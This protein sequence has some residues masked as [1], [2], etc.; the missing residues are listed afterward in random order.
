MFL[1]AT[2]FLPRHALH[3]STGHKLSKSPFKQIPDTSADTC[4]MP[5]VF[6]P[7]VLCKGMQAYILNVFVWCRIVQ[8]VCL[9]NCFCDLSLYLCLSTQS[10]SACRSQ[11]E[12]PSQHCFEPCWRCLS[13]HSMVLKSST[14]MQF[15]CRWTEILFGLKTGRQRKGWHVK[16]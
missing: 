6:Y 12:T 3:F 10:Q 8:Y 15:S 5:F 4:S 7:N 1:I 2:L 16:R 9:E 14:V 11:R 13:N